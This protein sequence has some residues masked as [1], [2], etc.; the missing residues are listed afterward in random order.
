MHSLILTTVFYG[1]GLGLYGTV[2]RFWQMAFV[3][4]VIGLQLWL[5]PI[6]LRNFRFGPVEWLWRSLTYWRRQ[7]F[8][9]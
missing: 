6:W 3:A 7:P 4:A 2:P 5:S 8:G 9:S 1:Y